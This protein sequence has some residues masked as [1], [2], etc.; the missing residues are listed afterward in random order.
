MWPLS[1]DITNFWNVRFRGQLDRVPMAGLK[2]EADG[3]VMGAGAGGGV[4]LGQKGR[5]CV[6]HG[7]GG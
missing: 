4:R 2:R 3:L 1:L 6:S 7:R 5:D